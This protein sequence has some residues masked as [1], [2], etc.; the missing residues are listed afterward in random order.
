LLATATTLGVK[1]YDITNGDQIAEITVP[2]IMTSK[3]ELSYSD[4]NFV[5]IFMD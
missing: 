5:V 1:I 4:K 3:V 2:G